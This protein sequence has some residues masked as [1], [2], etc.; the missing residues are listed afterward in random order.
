M[1]EIVIEC[2]VDHRVGLVC[3]GAQAVEI[4]KVAWMRLGACRRQRPRAGIGS[5][6]SQNLV[7]GCQQL[8]HDARANE[9]GRTCEK[10]AQCTL[11]WCLKGHVA[12]IFVM[13][14]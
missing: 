13:L 11:R 8:G 6:Q 9:T 7:P 2:R 3:A 5:R 4:L 10:N 12:L 1:G 14:K